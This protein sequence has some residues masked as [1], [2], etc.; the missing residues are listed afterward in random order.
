M[1]WIE[2]PESSNIARFYYDDTSQLL[3]VEFKTGITY[4]YYDIPATVYE[5]LCAASSKG[6]FLAT[7]VKQ[8]YRY[9]RV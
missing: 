8:T 9:A 1:N 2:T 6:Q 7:H 3:V 4:Q 5:S